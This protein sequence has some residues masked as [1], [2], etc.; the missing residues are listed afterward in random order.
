[1]V[2]AIWMDT[3]ASIDDLYLEYLVQCFKIDVIVGL[4]EPLHLLD[5]TLPLFTSLSRCLLLFM[6]FTRNYYKYFAIAIIIFDRIMYHVVEY[7]D[8]MFPVGN[9]LDVQDVSV[10]YEYVEIL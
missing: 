8:E 4:V 3:F 9:E 6:L 10:S 7:E 5:L 1:M 2:L